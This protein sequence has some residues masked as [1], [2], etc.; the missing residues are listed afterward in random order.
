MRAGFLRKSWCCGCGGD[1]RM[2]QSWGQK[3]NQY[4]GEED[5]IRSSIRTLFVDAEKYLKDETQRNQI[6][7]FFVY[8]WSTTKI[9][10]KQFIELIEQLPTDISK[11]TMTTYEQ[12]LL[13]GEK[14]GKIEGEKIGVKRGKT[15]NENLVIVNAYAEGFREEIIAKLT[16]L[17]VK[18]V[19]KRFETLGLRK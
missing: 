15:E 11:E 7:S 12:I 2:D 18:E 17:S 10:D 16:G 8:L 14:K 13:R 6:L 4:Y 5:Y 3:T 19:L 1:M 9:K